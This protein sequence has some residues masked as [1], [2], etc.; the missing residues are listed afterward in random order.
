MEKMEGLINDLIN[1]LDVSSDALLITLLYEH[2]RIFKG[3]RPFE[4]RLQRT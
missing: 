4:R 2:N 1:K 3:K